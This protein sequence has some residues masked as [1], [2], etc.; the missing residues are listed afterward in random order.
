MLEL[1]ADCLAGVWGYYA[2]QRDIIAPRDIQTALAAANE[3]GDDALQKRARG[4][5]VPDSFTHGSSEQRMSWFTRG[6]ET[7]DPNQCDTFSAGI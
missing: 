1:Q 5:V 4:Y 6:I 2:W 7:G 3:I